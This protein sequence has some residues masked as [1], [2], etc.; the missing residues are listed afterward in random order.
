M[1]LDGTEDWQD[2]ITA[3]PGDTLKFRIHYTNTG[4]TE[5]TDVTIHDVL[6][7][8]LNYIAGST[9]ASSSRH[10]EGSTSPE[11]L[12]D[13]GLNIGAMIAGEEAWITYTAT[14]ADDSNLFPCGT[15][16]VYNNALVSTHDGQGED[17]TKVTVVREC[18]TVTSTPSTL[19]T[20]GPGEVLMAVAIVIVI[21]GGGYYFYRSQRMLRK[22]SAGGAPE[23]TAVP[24]APTASVEPETPVSETPVE[25]PTVVEEPKDDIV[26]D[27]IK[28]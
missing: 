22:V 25:E 1:A 16:S 2:E 23:A 26:A 12:F 18:A 27:G 13:G 24:A 11:V 28:N 19:P 8:G 10:P 9:F 21:G 6:P 15:T 3:K 14:V 4:T 5:Q 20:T 7:S 17:K